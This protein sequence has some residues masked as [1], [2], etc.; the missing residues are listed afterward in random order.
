MPV[1]YNSKKIIPAPFVSF[2]KEYQK[3]GDNKVISSLYQFTIKGTILPDR[4]SP[5]SSGVFY[6]GSGYPSDE[7]LTDDQ[8][9]G[10]ILRK[11]K[12]LLGLFAS[13]GYSLEFQSPDGTQPLRCYPQD[14]KVEFSD[15][16]WVYRCDYTI[17]CVANRVFVNGV[18]SEESD[19]ANYNVSEC[20]KEWQLEIQDEEKKIYR[21]THSVYAKG[22]REYNSGSI[23]A[24]AWINA[25]NYVLQKI[26]LGLTAERIVNTDVMD[27]TNLSAYNY[28][29][30]ASTDE[31]NGTYSVT[32]TWL[33]YEPQDGTKPAIEDINVDAR[34][35]LET[36]RISVTVQ[37][38]VTGLSVFNNS[39]Y[40]QESTRFENATARWN[41]LLPTL[42]TKAQTIAGVDLNPLAINYTVGTNDVT[43]V[44]SFSYEFDNRPSTNIPG[45]ITESISVTDQNASDVFAIIPILGRTAGPILQDI[46]TKKEKRRTISIE[47]QMAGQVYGGSAPSAPVTT[48]LVLSLRPAFSRIFTE[49]DQESFVIQNGR[50]SRQ[51]TFVWQ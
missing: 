29:R 5:D 20:R 18:Q 16:P 44:I 3:R 46:G 43:G 14:I 25:K 22:K 21:I 34:Y 13:E 35:A 33:C 26:G 7:S 6:T 9:M 4:G 47:A 10:S 8:K 30:I 1:S 45:A 51:T 40:E 17:T 38:T 28:T 36:N 27:A 12:A 39:N 23:T 37:G 19:V 50:Y 31:H 11:Q 48:A 24:E 49:S 41:D 42:L 2:S 32:E 15:G